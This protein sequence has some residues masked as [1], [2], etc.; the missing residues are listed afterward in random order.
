MYDDEATGCVAH[1]DDHVGADAVVSE[2]PLGTQ[3]TV[4]READK[5][6]REWLAP[7]PGFTPANP[8]APVW[9]EMLG[10][11][12]PTPCVTALQDACRSFRSGSG[13]GWD[14]LHPRALLRLPVLALHALLKLLI[15][16]E[17]LGA[18]PAGIG[19]VVIA[20]LPKPE[21]G[22]RPIGLFPSLVRVWMRVRLPIA[23]IWMRGHERPYF[24]GGAPKG[25]SGRCLEAS[26][27]SGDGGGHWQ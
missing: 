9:P 22:L 2:A 13:L 8:P 25:G 20:L 1:D 24:F 4:E 3:L 16:A 23:Q 18:W 15:L 10:E 5:W 17:L 14:G 19:C 6:A 12:L 26:G 7:V 21:G 27:Q 11:Q